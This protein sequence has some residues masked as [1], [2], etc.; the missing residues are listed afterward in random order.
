MFVLFK[1]VFIG[2]FFTSDPRS[3]QCRPQKFV[4]SL[5][6]ALLNASII[7]CAFIELDQ[8]LVYGFAGGLVQFDHVIGWDE[9][10][11]FAGEEEGL[12]GQGGNELMAVPTLVA[13][14]SEGFEDWNDTRD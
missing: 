11:A 12:L 13:K 9:F 14:K 6:I 1:I 7:M 8:F 2:D 5:K 4:D 3:F 10:V